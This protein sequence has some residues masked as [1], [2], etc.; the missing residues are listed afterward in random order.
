MGNIT[1][2][3]DL[4]ESGPD[5]EGCEYG[6]N[7]ECY[8]M[9]AVYDSYTITTRRNISKDETTV[10][11][12]GNCNTCSTSSEGVYTSTNYTSD[13]IC[14]SKYVTPA[15]TS[16]KPIFFPDGKFQFYAGVNSFLENFIYNPTSV[17]NWEGLLADLARA[18][19]PVPYSDYH[20]TLKYRSTYDFI[21]RCN[22]VTPPTSL[23]INA[24]LAVPD[25]SLDFKFNGISP[26]PINNWLPSASGSTANGVEWVV[27]ISGQCDSTITLAS[28]MNSGFGIA[29]I[30]SITAEDKY[31]SSDCDL[32]ITGFTGPSSAISGGNISLS[33]S[34]SDSSSQAIN[35][36]IQVLDKIYT[37]TGTVPA[38]TWNGTYANG[39]I[40]P[41][42]AYSATLIALRSDGQCSDSKTFNFNILPLP[43]P[44]DVCDQ[45]APAQSSVHMGTGDLMHDQDLF[46]LTSAPLL[47]GVTLYYSNSSYNGPLGP[48]W[49]HNH[50]IGLTVSANGTVVIR[51]GS[52]I[53]HMYTPSANGYTSQIGDTSM[54]ISIPG[55]GYFLTQK[56][57]T[58]YKF[59]SDYTL[60]T[61][62]DVLGN[63]LTYSYVNGFLIS[64]SD[65]H[66]RVIDFSYSVVANSSRL[67]DIKEPHQ[68]TY[69]YSFSYNNTSGRLYR[70]YLPA[71]D[72]G[73][74]PYWEY[75]Y[76]PSGLIKTK[77][78]PMGYK[79]QYEYDTIGRL[80]KAID[81]SGVTDP[82]GHTRSYSYDSSL[83]TVK[84][85]IFFEKDSG[86]WKYLY[87]TSRGLVKEKQSPDGKAT[88]YT[89]N[90]NN[91]LS[92]ITRPGNGINRVST[93]Y[94]YDANGNRMTESVP[95]EGIDPTTVTDPTTD[96]RTPTAF[97][98]T[99]ELTNSNPAFLNQIKSVSDMRNPANILTTS[100]TYTT[101]TDGTLLTTVTDPT[102]AISTI[103]QFPN[104]KLKEVIDSNQY[105]K[106]TPLKTSY[107]YRSSDG[108][109]ESVTAP[110][111]V[112]VW[113]T[114]YD[115]NGNNTERRIKDIDGT[116]RQTISMVYDARN[117]LKTSTVIASGQ[118]NIVTTYG[119]DANGNLTSVLDPELK[120]TGF[121]YT[122]N[123]QIK[124]IIDA[125]GKIT[126]LDYGNSGCTSCGGSG[127]VDKVKIVEDANHHQTTFDYDQNGRLTLEKD[128][129]NKKIFY[130][131]YDNGLVME[132]Y[133]ATTTPSRLLITYRYNNDKQLTKKQ[134][135]DGTQDTAFIYDAN[136][137]LQT[138]SNTNIS[139]T[140][141][142]HDSA[143]SYNGRLKS[144]TDSSGRQIY[145]DQYDKLGQ[146]QKVTILKG[147]G[148]DERTLDYAY[149]DAN[150]PLTITANS[151]QTFT[152]SYDKLGRRDSI[153]YPNG[154]T[155]KHTYDTLNR[156]TSIKH[157]TS[158]ATITFASYSDFDKTGNRKNKITPSGTESYSYDN[159]YRL[160]TALTPKGI[161]NYG[162]DDV[163]NRKNGPGP[164]DTA[165]VYDNANRMKHGQ[166][167]N[168]DY[169]NAGNQTGRTIDSATDKGWTLTWDLENRLKQLDKVR[170]DSNGV[171]IESRSISFKYDP[172]GRRVEKKL[173]AL[174]DGVTKN[175]IWTYVY[176]GDAIA[177]EI[178]TLPTGQIEKTWYTHGSG[179]D[180][181]LALERGGN[182]FYYHA[183][184]LGS[185]TAI[186]D[187]SAAVAQSYTYDSYGHQTP[188]TSFRN[189]LTWQGKEWD[190]ETGL[191][192]FPWREYDPMD[193]IWVSKDP[194]GFVAGDV[195]LY[196]MVQNNP[197]NWKDPSGL[198][199]NSLPSLP[200]LTDRFPESRT[201]AISDV[202]LGGVEV[203]GAVVVGV[204]S[205]VSYLAGPEFWPISV[206]GTGAS[207]EAGWDGV[208]R[209]SSGVSKLDDLRDRPI[210]KKSFCDKSKVS[211]F[212]KYYFKIK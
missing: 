105:G 169:D 119:Y 160:I 111:G 206:A 180:E 77:Q 84:N 7:N 175:S 32:A 149:T 184:G 158:T 146:R 1:Q 71:V 44:Q 189:S 122:Y 171:V 45:N 50:D 117:R 8:D 68:Y 38:T 114:G 205:V 155:T 113:F 183:D 134:Y 191:Y 188:S 116:L 166:Q 88:S 138:A 35:W 99:Y 31:K 132:K 24:N 168:Y 96:S 53:Y 129:E 54:L 198:I 78:D 90:A 195:N 170:K 25:T 167:F 150:R 148:A 22:G 136:G 177:V 199:S 63:A 52:D 6:Q 185:I 82:T 29:N 57:G 197:V 56:N 43:K 179:V 194:L 141:A 23:R 79:S 72:G 200:G 112:S 27:P 207:I 196:R 137:R 161:E 70:V 92:A 192:H 130:T 131:Y 157:D 12:N 42:G 128:P 30:N 108:L 142:Y 140:Y 126:T 125:N 65:Q 4:T 5:S 21:L 144:I 76:Y 110:D 209:I 89:Y 123:G 174:I 91:Q 135:S 74:Q 28:D 9:C 97:S 133:D 47:Q 115:G 212:D 81:P 164:K 93:F 127:G 109:L 11:R 62:T 204:A 107:T 39:R 64:V 159:I 95:V 103:R 193:G 18:H 139:Y 101:D 69:A 46:T 87:D 172:F 61:V 60:Q 58:V 201:A 143:S 86:Q 190:R 85:N 208:S 145:Y 124:R 49:S 186:T 17:E 16:C 210:K 98:Y 80:T 51:T 202:I 176:D 59:A 94:T 40:V 173:T 83:E 10:D 118:L 152:Y 181:H 3:L 48:G 20:R 104:G 165:Y 182:Y 120:S 156:M 187:A 67:T 102:S 147:T 19:A 34:I 73:T 14:L 36:T 33:G 154:I 26:L 75:T 106:P 203:G 100:Y 211:E 41:P 163:G 15:G 162:Y 153:G 2:E 178:Y 13:G 66:G 55:G 37:G 121:D 151:A